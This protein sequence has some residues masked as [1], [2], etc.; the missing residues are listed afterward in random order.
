MLVP[1]SSAFKRA[2][3]FLR[4][5]LPTTGLT[6]Y[7]RNDDATHAFDLLGTAFLLLPANFRSETRSATLRRWFSARGDS[8]QAR[9]PIRLPSLPSRILV[10]ARYMCPTRHFRWYVRRYQWVWWRAALQRKRHLQA[11]PAS[12]WILQAD[13]RAMQ[14]QRVPALYTR[15]VVYCGILSSTGPVRGSLWWYGARVSPRAWMR[16]FIWV[17]RTETVPSNIGV[18]QG[19]SVWRCMCT[20]RC[21]SLPHRSALRG[22]RRPRYMPPTR[23]HRAALWWGALGLWI[24]THMQ[25]WWREQ[26]L[27]PAYAW[28]R[29]LRLSTACLCNRLYVCEWALQPW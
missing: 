21:R 4:R 29:A 5:S 3:N 11:W 25:R 6:Q 13:G 16:H 22:A 9:W 27:R 1:Y 19:D 2:R 18:A 26:A 23:T 28:K 14:A 24:W 17:R 20:K 12:S 15:L 10:F 7:I 8:M